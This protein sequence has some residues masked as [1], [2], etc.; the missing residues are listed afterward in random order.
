M[1]GDDDNVGT[2]AQSTGDTKQDDH[3]VG[4][5]AKGINYIE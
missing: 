3:D 4:T 5:S 1:V 2:S